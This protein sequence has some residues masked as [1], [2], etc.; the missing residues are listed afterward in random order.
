MNKEDKILCLDVLALLGVA[1]YCFF[2]SMFGSDFAEIST[3][4]SF[5]DFPIF[6]GEQLIFILIVLFAIKTFLM[7]KAQSWIWG[8]G[9]YI[10][11]ILFAS[12]MGYIHWGPLT[13]RN[14][15]LFY[16]VLF[17]LFGYSFYNPRIFSNQAVIK[18]IF[19]LSL[20][21]AAFKFI[22]VYF[23]YSYVVLMMVIVLKR[24]HV[25]RWWLIPTVFF[26][27]H[28]E[29]LFV[30]KRAHMVGVFGSLVFFAVVLGVYLV[31]L[32]RVLKLAIF[33]IFVLFIFG[34][35]KLGDQNAIKS[36]LDWKVITKLYATHK[37]YVET[38]KESYKEK[39]IVC[40]LYNKNLQSDFNEGIRN[41]KPVLMKLINTTKLNSRSLSAIVQNNDSQVSSQEVFRNRSPEPLSKTNNEKLHVDHMAK[42]VYVN[43]SKNVSNKPESQAVQDRDLGVAHANILFRIFVWEDMWNELYPYKLITG[44]GLGQPQR[45]S[46]IEIL[47]WGASEWS[48]DGW[49]M[50]H[51]SFFHMVYR[52]GLI[53]LLVILS[54]LGTLAYLTQIFV[55]RKDV[56]GVLLISVLVYWCLLAMFSVTLE[57]PYY[58][59][60][61]WSLLGLTMAY[62]FSQ[63]QYENQ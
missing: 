40:K 5:L 10:G 32:S 21:M 59:I 62:A 31:K 8:W 22:G 45:S 28:Y 53:G 19:L 41:K 44:V 58:A 9:V 14:A 37:Q 33:A 17:V 20:C 16:Y 27:A 35:N 24:F 3:T 43:D 38:H 4:V 25:Y 48:R 61:F 52:A 36:I 23:W 63:R 30:G 51:N 15:A 2:S 54:L 12:L 55:R 47:N 11:W 6:I 46:S 56:S 18:T 49:I 34:F 1:A 26:L 13:L 39:P 57:L 60:L 29:I 50:P 42:L 7:K